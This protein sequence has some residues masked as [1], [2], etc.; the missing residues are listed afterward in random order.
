[1]HS[2]PKWL[3]IL[4]LV[5]VL[6]LVLMEDALARR[7]FNHTTNKKIVL[8]LVL[9]EDALAQKELVKLFKNN[10]S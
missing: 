2:H 5:K 6:I 1:M 10:K 3:K 7:V 4:I 8:I 9:M